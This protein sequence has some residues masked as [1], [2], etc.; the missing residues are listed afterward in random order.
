MQPSNSHDELC[1]I[2][3][4][5]LQRARSKNGPGC[6]VAISEPRCGYLDGEIPDA[7]GF[8]CGVHDE[9]STVV[10]VKV[11]RADFLA[12]RHKPHRSDEVAGMGLYRYFMTP[13][14][15]L[16]ADELPEGWGLIEVNEKKHIKVLVGHVLEKCVQIEGKWTYDLEQWQHPRNIEREWSML[17]RLVMKI[18]DVDEAQR[19]IRDLYRSKNDLAVRFDKLHADHR[20]LKADSSRARRVLANPAIEKLAIELGLIQPSD[21]PLKAIPRQVPEAPWLEE[22]ITL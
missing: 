8:R 5:W 12:D 2:A 15:L 10:E 19:K 20:A 7:I 21:V 14:G 22:D 9:Y 11:S 6:Q 3:V 1:R 17:A 18:G 13:V 16:R 4:G